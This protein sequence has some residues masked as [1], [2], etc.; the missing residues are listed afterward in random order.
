MIGMD[1]WAVRRILRTAGIVLVGIYGIVCAK[2]PTDFGFLD[3]VDLIFHE[4][5][6]VIFGVF[7]EFVGVLGG[8]LMQVL[9]PVSI[10]VYFYVH[11]QVYS[12]AVVLFW[13]AQNCFNISVYIKDARAQVLPLLGE[14]H[15]WN[16]LLGRLGLLSWD[17]ALGNL[18]YAVGL[19]LLGVS[20]VGGLYAALGREKAEL[21]PK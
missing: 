2:D 13:V 8:T 7:G 5:G 15:D 12:A 3:G 16:Y 1:P 9:V 6:H 19:V 11:R 10:V 20:V 14:G 18:V 4:A 17:Q 21:V